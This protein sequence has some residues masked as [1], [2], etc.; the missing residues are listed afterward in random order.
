MSI[1]MNMLSDGVPL[2]TTDSVKFDD[3]SGSLKTVRQIIF[4]DSDA[5]FNNRYVWGKQKQLTV[6]YNTSRVSSVSVNRFFCS[7]ADMSTGYLTPTT[8][9]SG[10]KTFNVNAGDRVRIEAV[11]VSGYKIDSGTGEVSIT[12]AN[13]NTVSVSIVASSTSISASGRYY[14]QGSWTYETVNINNPSDESL[15]ITSLSGYQL[16]DLYDKM[17]G[18]TVSAQSIGH[19]T[20]SIRGIAPSPVQDYYNITIGFS[21]GSTVNAVITVG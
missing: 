8:Q 7:N 11:P 18:Q 14:T 3:G 4:V 19:Y 17:I 21:N 16:P 5:L 12:P 9:T 1:L 10:S 15:T 6:T 20:G 2:K 13:D